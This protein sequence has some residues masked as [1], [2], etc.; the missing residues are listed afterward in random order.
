MSKKKYRLESK[1]KG[2]VVLG[3][4]KYRQQLYDFNKQ[5]TVIE[6]HNWVVTKSKNSPYT[7]IDY[8]E[9]AKDEDEEIFVEFLPWKRLEELGV[10]EH[11]KV[12]WY[13]VKGEIEFTS[14]ENVVREISKELKK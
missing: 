14:L 3:V 6:D 10:D 13:R 9:Y 12:L 1:Y 7:L 8:M 2:E 5:K 4:Y 11:T